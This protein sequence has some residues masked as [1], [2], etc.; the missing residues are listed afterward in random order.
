MTELIRDTA[1][2][3]LIRFVSRGKYL[4]YQEEAD[5]S[6][7]TRFIDEKKSGY[8]A[9]HGDTNAP[10]DGA[11]MEGI[12]G[13][14]TRDDRYTLEPPA[15]RQSMVRSGSGSTSRTRVGDDNSHV[16]EVSGI[17]IDPEKGRDLHMVSWYGPDDPGEQFKQR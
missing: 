5:P 15:N 10:E 16:N 12:G 13:I 8:L 2:G 1:F 6:I 3:H 9:H 14:R 4:K 11:E 7:W 17:K